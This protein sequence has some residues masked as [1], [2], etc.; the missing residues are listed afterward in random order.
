M[1][2]QVINNSDL[3]FDSLS[4]SINSGGETIDLLFLDLE[5]GEKS[6]YRYFETLEYVY[7]NEEII[8]FSN[9]FIGKTAN[10]QFLE[11]GWGFCGTGLYFENT[12]KGKFK[13]VISDVDL[14]NK[15]ML[16]EQIKE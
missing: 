13:A 5:V 12:D 9:Y 10:D 6:P 1:S 11:T 14:I 3:D 4:F 16:I 2:I 15:R 7:Y 8:Y